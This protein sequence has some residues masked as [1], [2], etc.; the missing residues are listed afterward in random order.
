M[1]QLRGPQNRSS[2]NNRPGTSRGS[3]RTPP[4]TATPESRLM[5]VNA[6]ANGLPEGMTDLLEEMSDPEAVFRKFQSTP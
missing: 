2:T 6:M 3:R 4:R 1:K 5:T